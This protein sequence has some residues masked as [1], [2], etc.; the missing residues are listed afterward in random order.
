MF[1]FPPKLLG[2]KRGKLGGIWEYKGQIGGDLG[3]KKSEI[4]QRSKNKLP[5]L[6]LSDEIQL[7]D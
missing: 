7:L 4:K 1:C 3:R 5:F 6:I 2:M